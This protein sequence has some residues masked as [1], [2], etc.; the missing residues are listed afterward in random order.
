MMGEVQSRG[1]GSILPRTRNS[2]SPFMGEDGRGPST[3]RYYAAAIRM[4]TLRA[5]RSGASGAVRL[6]RRATSL[7][8]LR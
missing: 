5:R 7:P 1:W 4:L 8:G 6:R 3:C 2:T